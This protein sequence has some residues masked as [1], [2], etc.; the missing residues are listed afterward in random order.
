MSQEIYESH[1][2]VTLHVASALYPMQPKVQT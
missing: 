1:I 2:L